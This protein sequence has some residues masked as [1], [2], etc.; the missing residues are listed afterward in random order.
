MNTTNQMCFWVFS[1]KNKPVK[2][3]ASNSKGSVFY[4]REGEYVISGV[5]DKPIAHDKVKI[6]V[7][8]ISVEEFTQMYH[9]IHKGTFSFSW[10]L[11]GILYEQLRR[12]SYEL[13]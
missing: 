5:S 11:N 9:E 4:Y 13:N 12:T 2:I 7:Q 8:L 1:E 6:G 3:A 10:T